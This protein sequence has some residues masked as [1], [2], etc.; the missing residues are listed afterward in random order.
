MT[1]LSP[2]DQRKTAI[3]LFL[4]SFLSLYFELL[5]IRWLSNDLRPMAV[6]KT[7]PLVSCFVGLGLG[8]AKCDR[9]LFKWCPLAL[10]SSIIF[11]K[12]TD[13]LGLSKLPY[14]MAT[15]YQWGQIKNF[16]FSVW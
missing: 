12:A 13:L 10:L 2:S 8:F 11:V 16:D 14:P 1:T 5:V 9:N 15:L 7:F 4:L 3:E 6:L